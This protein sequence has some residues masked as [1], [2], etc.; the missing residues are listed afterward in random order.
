M[1]KR[2][3]KRRFRQYD[4]ASHKVVD[5]IEEKLRAIAAADDAVSHRDACAKLLA[6]AVHEY[7]EFVVGQTRYYRN[8]D[9]TLGAK[10]VKII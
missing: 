8:E 3:V 1:N 2:E 7:G 4:E 9:G 6:D 5:A 10:A